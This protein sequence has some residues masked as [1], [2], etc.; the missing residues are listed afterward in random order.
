MN[1]HSILGLCVITA[2]GVTLAVS[3]VVAQSMKDLVG[4]WTLVSAEAFGPSPKGGLMFDANGHA[5]A[6]G[7]VSGL[8]P[9]LSPGIIRSCRFRAPRRALWNGLPAG[10]RG[11]HG[12]IRRSS[13]HA[14]IPK[15]PF[16]FG[17]NLPPRHL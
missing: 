7:D 9:P 2:V 15:A 5:D 12:E 13:C 8:M 4:T 6:Y 1:R 3:N 16:K 11:I 17:C 14:A 10:D